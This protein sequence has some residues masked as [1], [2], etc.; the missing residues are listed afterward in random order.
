MKPPF[1]ITPIELGIVTALGLLLLA[2]T[3]EHFS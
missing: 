2:Y 3:I 1:R